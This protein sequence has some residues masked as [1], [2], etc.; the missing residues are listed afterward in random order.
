MDVETMLLA[1]LIAGIVCGLVPLIAGYV[2]GRL[3]L[4]IIGFVVTALSGLVLGL[5][6][7]VPVAIVFTLFIVLSGRERARAPRTAA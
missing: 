4:G 5:L 6:L 3:Q 2:K 7:A 1:G